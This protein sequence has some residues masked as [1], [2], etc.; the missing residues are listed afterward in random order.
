V[1]LLTET[2][3][4][5]G[6][7]VALQVE[8][9]D[10]RAETVHVRRGKGGKGRLVPFGPQTARARDRYLRLR[11]QHRLA[12]IPALW[13]G[14]RG[15]GFGY[16]ALHFTLAAAPRSRASAASILMCSGVPPPTAGWPPAA[17]RAA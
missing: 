3:V 14:D 7:K 1:R 13:L 10:L 17:A 15:R 11:R 6:E 4:R 8:D 2:G 12:A 16:A 5:A 9:L